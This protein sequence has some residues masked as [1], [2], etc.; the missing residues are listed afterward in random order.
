MTIDVRVDFR[1]GCKQCTSLR[2][3]LSAVGSIIMDQATGLPDADI[4]NMH[5]RVMDVIQKHMIAH[6]IQDLER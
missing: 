2:D 1:D 5:L 4:F 6:A 3:D